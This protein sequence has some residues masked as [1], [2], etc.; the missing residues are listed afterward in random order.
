V[1]LLECVFFSSP[2]VACLSLASLHF[3]QAVKA[4]TMGLIAERNG[5]PQPPRAFCRSNKPIFVRMK[6]GRMKE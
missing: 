3:R 6:N 1:T 5:T 4:L 2:D